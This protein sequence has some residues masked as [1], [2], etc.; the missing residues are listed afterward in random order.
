MRIKEWI[1]GFLCVIA[2]GCGQPTEQQCSEA[3]VNV[4][5]VY[6]SRIEEGAQVERVQ[7]ALKEGEGLATCVRS[8]LSEDRVYVACLREASSTKAL[9][10]CVGVSD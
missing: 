5:T 7:V 10:E 1:S 4:A 3:C 9:N 2:L 8:C 6:A